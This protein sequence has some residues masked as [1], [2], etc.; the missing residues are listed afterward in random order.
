MNVGSQ[1]ISISFDT[2][3]VVVSLTAP[4]AGISI[5][6][7]LFNPFIIVD[8]N[9][10]REV[11]MINYEPT[12]L[13]GTSDLGTVDDASIPGS[14]VYYTTANNYPWAI[15]IPDATLHLVDK[16]DM[17]TG[18]LDF[19]VWAQSGGLV[20]QGWYLNGANRNNSNLIVNP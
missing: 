9:R 8:Q 6:D 3:Q 12:A 7:A 19:A 2:I 4:I 10:S 14:G 5:G 20:N 17:V 13:S 15:D 16:S 1:G 11:H 18:H